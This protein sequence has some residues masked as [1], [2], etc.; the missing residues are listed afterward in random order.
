MGFGF[1]GSPSTV[2]LDSEVVSVHSDSEESRLTPV[3]SPGVSSVPEFDSI[4]FAPSDDSDFVVDLRKDLSLLIDSSSVGF[5]FQGGIDSAGNGS[6]GIDFSLHFVSSGNSSVLSDFPDGIFVPGPTVSFV[7]LVLGRRPGAV[8]AFLDIRAAELVRVLGKISLAGFLRDTVLVSVDVDFSGVSSVAASSSL[9]VDDDLR[10]EGHGRPGVLSDDVD[11]VGD[12]AGRSM[13]PAGSA[14]GGD[15]LVSGP[16]EIVGSVD[17]S[18]VPL[19]G[20]VFNVEVFVRSRPGHEFLKGILGRFSSAGGL[21]SGKG[22]LGLEVL[23][24][25]LGL[26]SLVV[27]P[28]V[29]GVGP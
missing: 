3:A 12:G 8:L 23:E 5:K 25:R 27:G 29:G 17:V 6:S 7:R 2:F 4:F 13:G 26:V 14:V 11:S 10:G 16:T 21:G 15:V 28:G 18:P 9:A 20:K 1:D 19:I 22:L 24:V